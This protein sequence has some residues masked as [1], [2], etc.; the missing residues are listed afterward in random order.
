MKKI[1]LIISLVFLAGCSL[2][3]PEKFA[4]YLLDTNRE[5]FSEDDLISYDLLSG[6]FT[7][8][9]EGAQKMKSYQTSREMNAGLYQKSFVARL[10]E[11]E[12]YSGK[13]WTGVSSMSEPGMVMTDVVMISPDYNTLTVQSSYPSGKISEEINNSKIIEH[14][15]KIGKLITDSGQ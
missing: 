8:T 10:G 11:E 14:F 4:V 2:N 12:L 13:F 3:K 1:L 6:I 15:K 5:V 9:E 7:F